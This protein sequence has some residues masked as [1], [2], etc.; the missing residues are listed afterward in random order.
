MEINSCIIEIKEE[1]I[2]LCT[3][4]LE[5]IKKEKKLKCGH[6]FCNNCI[7]DEELSKGKRTHKIYRCLGH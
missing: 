6:S 3:I 2:N 7:L 5:N 1:K 4:C